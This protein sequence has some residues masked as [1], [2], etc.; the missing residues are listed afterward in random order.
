LHARHAA[1][2]KTFHAN[3]AP[4]THANHV[5]SAAMSSAAARLRAANEETAGNR[6]TCQNH[7]HSLSHDY[8]LWNG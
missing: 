5:T 6:G 3:S 8:L 4:D 2:A 1:T 7:Q